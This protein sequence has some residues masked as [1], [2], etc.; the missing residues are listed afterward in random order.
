MHESLRGQF[1]AQY[2]II[3]ITRYVKKSVKYSKLLYLYL[4]YK[5][6]RKSFFQHIY[7]VFVLLI[8]VF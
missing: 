3:V 4:K 1:V 8:V 2:C 7:D 5:I 6:I